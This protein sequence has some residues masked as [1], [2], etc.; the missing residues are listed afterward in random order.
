MV[1][2]ISITLSI[3]ALIFSIYVFVNNRRLDK[4][5][6]LIKMHELLISDRHQKGRYLLFEKVTDESSV[7]R[8]SDGDYRDINGAISG[9]SLLGIYVE[10]GYINER[11][12]LEAWAIPIARAWEAAKPFIAHRVNRQGYNTH[13]GFEPLARRAQEY[14]ARNG[15]ALE[16]KAWRR[17]DGTGGPSDSMDPPSRRAD[18][19]NSERGVD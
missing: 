4:R 13:L 2:A 16:Y 17:T 8:L 11:D 18:P 12:A 6:T 7:E 9:F 3:A 15:K 10:N 14:L 19:H 1:A 5:N